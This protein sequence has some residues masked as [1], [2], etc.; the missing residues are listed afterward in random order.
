MHL[1][2]LAAGT[3]P[4]YNTILNTKCV[5]W[6]SLLLLSHT[7]LV[8]RRIERNNTLNVQEYSFQICVVFV[9]LHRNFNSVGIFFLNTQVSKFLTVRPVG[10]EWIRADGQWRHE[11]NSRFP[12]FCERTSK[13]WNLKRF[14]I[15]CRIIQSQVI[16]LI[17]VCALSRNACM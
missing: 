11:G 15:L 4:Q 6:F 3:L 16:R 5:F 7:F 14:I 13:L 17:T 2:A 9:K 1:G 10:D 12:K 8:L